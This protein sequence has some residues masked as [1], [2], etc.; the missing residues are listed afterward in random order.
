[1]KSG[2]PL[3]I[4][5][6][7]ILG[8]AASL[9]IAVYAE[10][11]YRRLESANRQMGVA[12][13]MQ[14][15][16]FAVL[17]LVVDAE[18]GQRGYLL[19]GR[20]EYLSPY[21]AS[22]PKI[23]TAVT[24]LRERLD[25]A[26][27]AEQRETLGRINNLI[28]KKLSE[29][30]ASLALYRDHGPS[31]A[32]ALLDTGIGKRAME[33]IRDEVEA[34]ALSN[35]Q[36]HDVAT[37]R[38]AADVE[39]GRLGMQAMTALSVALLVVIWLLA[40]RDAREREDRRRSA[41]EEN[42]RLEALV[43]RRTAELS[44]LSNHLQVVREEEKAKL[45]RDIH[46]ELGGMLVGVK[47]DMA[48]A[49]ERLRT[50]D[51]DA[52]AKLDRAMGTLDEGISIKRRIIEELRPTMLDNLGLSSALDW[53]VHEVCDRA[54]LGCTIAT[55]N[56]DSGIAPRVS[57]ALYRVVQ[58]ALTNIVK[59]A[60]AKNVSV[61][62]GIAADSTSLLIE[63]DGVGIADGAESNLLSHGIAGMRQRIRALHGDFSIARRREGGTLIEISIPSGDRPRA[64]AEVAP[65]AA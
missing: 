40:R 10:L 45:A 47:M 33:G 11:G 16:L 61:D 63:D 2:L 22:V 42:R 27:T 28:G 30:E 44:E 1:M 20:D 64:A 34:M 60:H 29:L 57:I 43:E 13:E 37:A 21:T 52:V 7:L 23:E 59:Y 35:Q 65:A 4:V 6:P 55:P 53:Q 24:R 19:T 51:P 56:D 50:Q 3:K 39:F 41:L 31:A 17:A 48:W 8:I 62:L 32:Q 58:E 36:Q 9:A 46:D 15:S 18:T 26:G 49:A 12:M 25:T 38:W 5:M 14:A 54:G